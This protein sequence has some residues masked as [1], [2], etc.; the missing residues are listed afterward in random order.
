MNMAAAS[1]RIPSGRQNA[2]LPSKPTE[3]VFR[4]RF[5][6][7]RQV[8][9]GRN[10]W[11]THLV[12]RPTTARHTCSTDVA[13]HKLLLFASGWAF[14]GLHSPARADEGRRFPSPVLRRIFRPHLV[15]LVGKKHSSLPDCNTL[16][17]KFPFELAPTFWPRR[18]CYQ[19]TMV[20]GSPNPT[21]FRSSSSSK[22]SRKLCNIAPS[23]LGPRVGLD[24]HVAANIE[25]GNRLPTVGS[26][27][28][29]ASALGVSAGWLAYGLGPQHAEGPPVTD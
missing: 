24:V 26:V 14:R 20:R 8:E 23:A 15:G 2:S 16:K 28:R 10:G 17:L 12:K 5:T 9:L 3:I 19:L 29:L 6:R 22:E 27:A 21:S 7:F 18:P 25:A 13:R 4:P 1:R 11:R